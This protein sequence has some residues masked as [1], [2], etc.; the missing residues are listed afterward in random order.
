MSHVFI[1]YSHK[2]VHHRDALIAKLTE[3]GID[4]WYDK[5]IEG[6]RDW[7]DEIDIALDEAFA[8]VVIVTTDAMESHAVTYEWSWATGNGLPV[9]AL[10]F[11]E[12]VKAKIHH[13]LA[14]KQWIACYESIPEHV[15][16]VLKEYEENPPDTIYL[17]RLILQTIMPL[18][19]YI[20]VTLWLYEHCRSGSV[21]FET[22]HDLVEQT[23]KRAGEAGKKLAEFMV[24]KSYAFT[25]KQRRMCRKLIRSIDGFHQCLDDLYP[26][27]GLM[28][29]YWAEGDSVDLEALAEVE[30]Y[31]TESFEPIA[32]FF[33][34][35]LAY[36]RESYSRFDN[37]LTAISGDETVSEL[38][39]IIYASLLEEDVDSIWKIVETVRTK[40]AAAS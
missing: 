36:L 32:D 34:E 6:G 9:I 2:D 25:S 3:A 23:Q 16:D 1:S 27:V 7:R 31:R 4:Y 40:R 11:N 5:Y 19:I 8:I 10:I 20:R 12:E 29:V 14:R 22:F 28:R 33:T 13:A 37:Y 30:H 18:R 38:G 21:G 17:S 15:I 39:W 24:D 26:L 35:D